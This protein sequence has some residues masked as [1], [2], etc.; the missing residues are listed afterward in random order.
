MAI[1]KHCYLKPPDVAPVLI[2]FNYDAH[3]KIDR[4]K[5]Y[6]FLSYRKKHFTQLYEEISTSPKFRTYAT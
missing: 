5:N 4:E 1:M 6:H 2:R 3:G